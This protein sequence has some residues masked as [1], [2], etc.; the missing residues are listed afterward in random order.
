M[1]GSPTTSNMS[2]HFMNVVKSFVGSNYLA[3]P[4]IFLLGGVYFSCYGV[5][6]IALLTGI[7]CSML[8]KVRQV[9][10]EKG[11]IPCTTYGQVAMS[12]LG[13][14]GYALVEAAMLL[15][16]IGF[17]IGYIIF[18]ATAVYHLLSIEKWVICI[19]LAIP[20]T[21]LVCVR[22]LSLFTTCSYIA[23]FA[24]LVGF[25]IILATDVSEIKEHGFKQEVDIHWSRLPIFF[26]VLIACFEGIGTVLPVEG[27]MGTQRGSYGTLLW[28]VMV[29]ITFLFSTFGVLGVGRY[30]NQICGIIL[31]N[32]NDGIQSD[33]IKI[34]V[35]IGLFFTYAF[36]MFPVFEILGT[37]L[38][39]S[40]ML[41]DFIL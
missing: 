24:L 13:W 17:C 10:R 21:A 11:N 16:Q 38:I 41:F 23:N 29:G 5:A 30:G 26:G 20:L 34:C 28:I 3:V 14:K 22:D 12:V 31:D 8:V 15:T 39:H 19:A 9:L 4:H 27:A 25:V 36:Q 33:V 2:G 32:L 1:S 6:F 35:T 37:V 18:M 40:F 7:C